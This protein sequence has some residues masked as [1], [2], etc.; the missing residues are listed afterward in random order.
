[1]KRREFLKKSS[2][3]MIGIAAGAELG[4]ADP[5]QT[6][7]LTQA[8]RSLAYVQGPMPAQPA[9]ET[10]NRAIL[11]RLPFH[12]RRD[13]ED[14]SRGFIAT[15]PETPDRYEFLRGDPPPTVNPSLWRQ[16]QLNA[17][18]GLFRVTGNVY[19][20]RGFSVANMTIVEGVTGIIVIDTLYTPGAAHAALDLYFAHRPHRPVVAVI[21]THN[22]ADHYGGASGVISPS[23]AAAGKTKVIAPAGFMDA[24]TNDDVVA[25]NL[26]AR[27]S[28]YQ[29]GFPLPVGERGNVDNGEAKNVSRGPGRAGPII[30][31]N[32]AIRQPMESRAIDGVNFTFLLAPDS[33]APSEMLIYMP[34]S[35]VLDAAEDA[36]H[37]LH[38]LLP[39][40]GTQVRDANL[41]SQY[42]N[43]A[44]DQFGGDVQ[45]VIDQ[46]TWPVW[47]NDRARTYLA[48]HRDLYKYI[49]DQTVRMMNEG[50]GPT[51]TAEALTMPPGLESDWSVRGYYGT[52][53]Q[54][55]RA[56]Y[57]R[58]VGWYD[59]N[60]ANLD[61]LLRVEE[62]K[63]YLEY[64][65]GS[66]AVIARARD[67]FQAGDYRWVVEVM[68]K[69]VFADPLNTEARNL[70]AA[71]FEQLGYLAES[72]ICRNAYL[73]GAQELRTGVTSNA[74]RVPGL[75]AQVLPMMS[76]GRVFDYLGT[77]ID[78]PRAGT[79]VIAINWQ[80][81]D[82]GES[83]T[84]TLQHGALTWIAG[85]TNPS[86]PTSVTTTRAVF[87]SVVLGQRTLPEAMK[88]GD[89]TVSGNP[90]AISDLFALLVEF[91]PGFPIVEPVQLTQ[92]Q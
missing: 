78:G 68:D 18:N 62:A 31:P 4:N 1:M 64:M 15:T 49:H 51:E 8:T 45:V 76:I 86:V 14:A 24:L 88:A 69:V 12:D 81:A 91:N 43:M 16:A 5:I 53:S 46:H 30:P 82:A 9:V 42:L 74:P 77:R 11:S 19:Q 44:L 92:M 50:M 48:N 36:G 87:E 22:H 6:D 84:S 47:G 61:R 90:K 70:G 63:K 79:A 39:L 41:W 2:A 52:L 32:E 29:F 72:A 66:A 13:F 57:Q 26:K 67:D 37:T 3:S 89:I 20:V 17:T 56:V 83:L 7:I 58:Y 75:R 25:G 65:G 59:G 34:Q 38:N 54:N 40:R 85:K 27:R 80:F 21:Y 10:A 35:H 23:D 28:Q 33:E 55:S 71:A 60:P 73:L